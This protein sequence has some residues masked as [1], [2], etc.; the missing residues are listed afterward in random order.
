MSYSYAAVF[1]RYDPE[2]R[3]RLFDRWLTPH[4]EP[5]RD[6]A[7]ATVSE[8]SEEQP[9]L[10]A[11]SQEFGEAI[12]FK[13]ATSVNAF[14][15]DHWSN[16]QLVRGLSYNTDQGWTRTVGAPEAWEAE[17]IF[18]AKEFEGLLEGASEAK[19]AELRALWTSGRLEAGKTLPFADPECVLGA[20]G[21]QFNLPGVSLGARDP[22]WRRFPVTG[23]EVIEVSG[24]WA[25][26]A[27][28]RAQAPLA[29]SPNGFLAASW[30]ADEVV[31]LWLVSSGSFMKD[32]AD[33]EAQPLCLAFSP[34]GDLLAAGM[35][36][37]ERCTL[38]VWHTTPGKGK[39]L[40]GNTK[41]YETSAVAFSPDG[42]RLASGGGGDDSGV[43]RLW[44]A[45]SGDR[46]WSAAD[47]WEGSAVH[48]LAFS[49]DGRFLLVG[50]WGGPGDVEAQLELRSSTDGRM[51]WSLP[52]PYRSVA[53]TPDGRFAAA[54]DGEEGPLSL[55][56]LATGKHMG[57]F[58]ARSA[59]GLTSEGKIVPGALRLAPSLELRFFNPGTD[60]PLAPGSA[61]LCFSGALSTTQLSQDGR[62]GFTQSAGGCSLVELAGGQELWRLAAADPAAAVACSSD[63][64]L[65]ILGRESG[66]LECVDTANL[67]V[68]WRAQ[69]PARPLRLRLSP[70]AKQVFVHYG[71]AHWRLWDGES[72]KELPRRPAEEQAAILSDGR[73]A[74]FADG[75][76]QAIVLRD[77]TTGEEYRLS[78]PI[79]H[80]TEPQGLKAARSAD[81]GR[82]LTLDRDLAIVWNARTGEQLAHA[83]LGACAALAPDAS[84]A[85]S[86]RG[87]R[88]A[89]LDGATLKESGAVDFADG[90]P[91]ACVSI[92]DDGTLAIGTST[93]ILLW[94][95]ARLPVESTKPEK[96]SRPAPAPAQAA[97]NPEAAVLEGERAVWE[98][99]V[100]TDPGDREAWL[101]KAGCEFRLNLLNKANSSLNALVALGM[102]REQHAAAV[103]LSQV[104]YAAHRSLNPSFYRAVEII[105][106]GRWE[107]SLPLLDASLAKVP[108]WAAAWANK[109][110]ALIELERYGEALPALDRS[111][112]LDPYLKGTMFNKGMALLSLGRVAEAEACYALALRLNA[113]DVRAWYHRGVCL[114]K[115]GR[116]AEGLGCLDE[117]L[118]LA[119]GQPEILAQRVL[120]A[121]GL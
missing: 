19:A 11:E 3:G 85:I 90:G 94:G 97:P 121:K 75:P 57:S 93:G 82:L 56:D 30:S 99:M 108:D 4:V 48:G 22:G 5:G 25:E 45:A 27:G 24:L 64:R 68:R 54:C 37:S 118:K 114:G 61:R 65:A 104:L 31:R 80:E 42:S 33:A 59:I 9:D 113:K 72:G 116:L 109:G 120:L 14:V 51:V 77:L 71:D 1:V 47:D 46:V 58:P 84:F 55:V 83:R 23:R 60:Q 74:V 13:I 26:G 92:G 76:G 78:G 6:F 63:G 35:Y 100:E 28:G 36:S 21:K 101:R 53:V 107:E 8:F 43:L 15:Y 117:A 34:K 29:L 62:L 18:S 44:D 81:G 106:A 7:I 12:G 103:E 17:A 67:L 112:A 49:P 91:L 98:L 73:T 119:P 52:G 70:D 95:R 20:L 96:P 115:L 38:A 69:G 50:R 40:W 88:L 111:Y 87:T 39:V 105:G 10:A 66:A 89:L 110:K 86:G 102:T 32:L 2:G 41:H 79:V 16:G